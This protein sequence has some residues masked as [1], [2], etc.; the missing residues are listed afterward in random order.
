MTFP[1]WQAI[2]TSLKKDSADLPYSDT[3]LPHPHKPYGEACA[4]MR[5][6]QQVIVCTFAVI[7]LFE[8][9]VRV[10]D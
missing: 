3:G 2:T 8:V 10:R 5:T 7:S 9:V 1:R 4:I 6:L